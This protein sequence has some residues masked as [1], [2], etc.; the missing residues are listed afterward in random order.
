[1]NSSIHNALAQSQ[2]GS[3]AGL[4]QLQSGYKRPVFKSPLG[5]NSLFYIPDMVLAPVTAENAL[6]EKAF[7]PPGYR[8]GAGANDQFGEP[9][10]PEI[11]IWVTFLDFESERIMDSF[12]SGNKAGGYPLTIYEYL[13]KYSGSMPLQM[14]CAYVSKAGVS[15]AP[16]PVFRYSKGFCAYINEIA[17]KQGTTTLY[18][19]IDSWLKQM[20]KISANRYGFQYESWQVREAFDVTLLTGISGLAGISPGAVTTKIQKELYDKNYLHY[21]AVAEQPT[22]PQTEHA[23]RVLCKVIASLDADVLQSYNQQNDVRYNTAY[24]RSKLT[25]NDYYHMARR[26]VILSAEIKKF[27]TGDFKDGDEVRSFVDEFLVDKSSVGAATKFII[28]YPFSKLSYERRKFLFKLFLD[29]ET[30]LSFSGFWRHNFRDNY[31]TWGDVVFNL[32]TTAS[33]EDTKR[34]FAELDTEN[35]LFDLMQQ[36][37]MEFLQHMSIMITDSVLSGEAGNGD[38]GVKLIE[39][40][41]TGNYFFYNKAGNK[42]QIA[43]LSGRSKKIHIENYGYDFELNE[44]EYPGKSSTDDYMGSEGFVADREEEDKERWRK[45]KYGE[46]Q[47]QKEAYLNQF[48][49][50]K[51]E[52]S[53]LDLIVVVAEG[54]IDNPLLK[55]KQDEMAIIPACL[56][57]AIM[58]YESKKKID[59]LVSVSLFLIFLP[60]DYLALANALRTAN[61]LGVIAY[62]TDIAVN[63]VNVVVSSPEV[64]EAFPGLTT[65]VHYFTFFWGL[66]RLGYVGAKGIEH[67]ANGNLL[68]ALNYL[69]KE[70]SLFLKRFPYKVAGF[71]INLQK[72]GV[73]MAILNKLLVVFASD[74]KILFRMSPE[75]V[76]TEM[77]LVT[78]AKDWEL[79]SELKNAKIKV[80]ALGGKVFEEHVQLMKTVDEGK[81]VLKLATPFQEGKQ[82]PAELINQFF[83]KSAE[84]PP[85]MPRTK[86]EDIYL[87]EGDSFYIVEAL[88]QPKPGA[89]AAEMPVYT[90]ADLRN[91]L[92]V[93]RKWKDETK[94]VLVIRKY[95]VQPKQKV[96]VRKSIIGPQEEEI[97]GILK[98]YK[99]GPVQYNFTFKLDGARVKMN[100]WETLFKEDKAFE[101]ILK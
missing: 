37:D 84:T 33:K 25:A 54:D 45:E 89:F 36:S 47:A 12:L 96:P 40:I 29:G 97:N 31:I 42:R 41:A 9:G 55:L 81:I 98:K 100:N 21:K 64:Q 58:H 72:E 93:L 88:N 70:T 80:P 6:T 76:I 59:F 2:S 49:S 101:Q 77:K 8:E 19:H 32:L 43:Y 27:Q 26:L 20:T 68:R 66:A 91:K 44:E 22:D 71:I 61:T 51:K 14:V 78:G 65:A 53:A 46:Y 38:A 5:S 39:A 94:N 79:I 63:S 60:L 82:R 34:L 85:S 92:A 28:N 10:N 3:N 35:K 23:I 11:K 62:R 16:L 57:Y 90:V 17:T 30:T 13:E 15:A 67:V 24:G 69:A 95:T 52:F 18:E 83:F 74:G 75:G 50:I 48:S 56:L 99:G 1:M 87:K 7:R 4:Q 86:V 73:Q